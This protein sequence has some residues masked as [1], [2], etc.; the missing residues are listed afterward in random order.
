MHPDLL[1]G[2]LKMDTTMFNRLKNMLQDV[3]DFMF[4][5]EYEVWADFGGSGYCEYKIADFKAEDAETVLHSALSECSD[6]LNGAYRVVVIYKGN[7]PN[8]HGT[9]LAWRSL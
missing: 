2:T 3:N 7:N 4:Q 8:V 5:K 9:V 6:E 1:F